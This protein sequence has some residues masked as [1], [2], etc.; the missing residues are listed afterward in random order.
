MVVGF[1]VGKW[2]KSK[3][4]EDERKWRRITGERSR[5]GLDFGPV[6]SQFHIA[7]PIK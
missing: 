1:L 7:E 4:L 3:L 2:R 5:A 6:I